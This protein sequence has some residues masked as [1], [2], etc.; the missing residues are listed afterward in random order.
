[1]SSCLFRGSKAQRISFESGCLIFRADG[2][3]ARVRPRTRPDSRST[4]SGSKAG[5]AKAPKRSW[6]AGSVAASPQRGVVEVGPEHR[7]R[8][9]ERLGAERR[10]APAHHLRIEPGGLHRIWPRCP[11]ASDQEIA[12]ALAHGAVGRDLQASVQRALDDFGVDTDPLRLRQDARGLGPVCG[13]RQ[14][15]QPRTAARTRRRRPPDSCP[16]RPAGPPAPSPP[17]A[18]GCR[19]RNAGCGRRRD[20]PRSNSRARRRRRHRHGRWRGCPTM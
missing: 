17:R 11:F 5:P 4:S 16:P 13:S 2:L 1:M 10:L 19:R 9:L 20:R 6:R 3:A 12:A 15:R 8:G 14:R 7:H 18:P